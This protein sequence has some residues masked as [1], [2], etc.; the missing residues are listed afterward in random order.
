[1]QQ[2]RLQHF[3]QQFVVVLILF[4]FKQMLLLDMCCWCRHTSL[5][6]WLVSYF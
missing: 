5:V 6:D 2:K 1:M 3:M 4:I